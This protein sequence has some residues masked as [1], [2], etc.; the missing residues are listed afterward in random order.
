[1]TVTRRVVVVAPTAAAP[2]DPVDEAD[3]ADEALE[4][5]RRAITTAA[6]TPRTTRT[7]G[8]TIQPR[9]G[10]ARPAG[11]TPPASSPFSA[12]AARPHDRQ[13]RDPDLIATPQWPHAGALP[14][15]DQGAV[16]VTGSGAVVADGTVT[17]DG[18]G[19][20]VPVEP[21]DTT[22]VTMVPTGSC[23]FAAGSWLSTLPASSSVPG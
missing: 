13:K 1:M 23:V 9:V 4:S 14:T 10:D 2:S 12:D 3:E 16:T 8:N 7:A 20:V 15:R 5:S 18:S 22:I 21:S 17:E 11:P 6:S 19:D